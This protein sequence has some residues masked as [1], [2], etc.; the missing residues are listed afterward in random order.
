MVISLAAQ[1]AWEL[2]G[3]DEER[4]EQEARDAFVEH[5]KEI[6]RGMSEPVLGVTAV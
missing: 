2:A 5:F 3:R 4:S 1:V 6:Y